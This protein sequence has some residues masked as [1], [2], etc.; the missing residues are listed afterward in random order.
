M[1]TISKQEEY[2]L[3]R[4]AAD[5]QLRLE[6]RKYL[7]PLEIKELD[8]KERKEEEEAVLQHEAHSLHTELFP[9]E[10]F[11]MGDLPWNDVSIEAKEEII[12]RRMEMGFGSSYGGEQTGDTEKF[13]L[14]MLRDGKHQEIIEL[15]EKYKLGDDAFDEG[16]FSELESDPRYPDEEGV[17]NIES[18]HRRLFVEEHLERY[19]LSWPE[20]PEKIK[21]RIDEKRNELG[22]GKFDPT[23][24]SIETFE[25][26]QELVMTA[27]PK[28]IDSLLKK[29]ELTDEELFSLEG[30]PS[31]N[32][33][34]PR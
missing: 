18:L 11:I 28:I 14:Q 16:D 21:V 26:L 13:V 29:H 15:I 33:N 8:E 6:E 32:L 22:F 12:K 1:K 24:L 19:L 5:A 23:I 31:H 20:L 3:R 7:S 25:F 17:G 10:Y 9:E 30:K 34:Y 2:R 4:V 27:D